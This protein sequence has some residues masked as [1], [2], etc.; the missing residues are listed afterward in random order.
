MHMRNWLLVGAGVILC[1]F[2]LLNWPA[3]TRPMPISLLIVTVNAPLG[4]VLLTLC[5][6]IIAVVMG[7]ALRVQVTAFGDSRRQMAELRSQRELAD[8][9]EQSRFMALRTMLEGEFALLRQQLTEVES[10]LRQESQES[11][12]SLAACIGEIDDRLERQA[13]IPPALLP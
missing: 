9:A 7:Y 10:R 5:G 1:S 6:A 12:N 4:L 3:I 8:Q 11:A 13:P 2:V